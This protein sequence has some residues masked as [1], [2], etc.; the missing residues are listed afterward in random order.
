VK[1]GGLGPVEGFNRPNLEAK[2]SGAPRASDSLLSLGTPAKSQP[3]ESSSTK[4]E[5]DFSSILNEKSSKAKPSPKLND[6]NEQAEAMAG[7]SMTAQPAPIASDKNK[8]V[9]PGS[10]STIEPT[11]SGAH[12]NRSK[13]PAAPALKS[14]ETGSE[15]AAVESGEIS[16]KVID[17]VLGEL[18]AD[19]SMTSQSEE[20][21]RSSSMQDFLSQMKA[22]FGIQPEAVIK[23]FANLSP[24]ALAASPEESAQELL[25]GLGLKPDQMPKAERMYRDM[26]NVTGESALNETMAGVGAGVTMKVLSEQEV[27]LEKLQKSITSLNDSFAIRPPATDPTVIPLDN[28]MADAGAAVVETTVPSQAKRDIGASLKEALETSDPSSP[29]GQMNS[30]L[31]IASVLAASSA[32]ASMM[33]GKDSSGGQASQ[34][35]GKDSS[36]PTSDNKLES[37]ESA[38]RDAGFAIPSSAEKPAT[39]LAAGTSTALATA[40]MSQSDD[41]SMKANAQDVVRNAQLLLRN[42]GGEMKM[43]LKPEGVGEIHLKVAVKDGQVAVQMLT[44]SDSAKK[45]LE[46]GIEDLKTSLAQNKLHVDAL[47]I[48]V[49]TEMA[50]QRFEQSQQESGREQARQLAQ[51]FLGSFRQ[52]REAFRHGFADQSGFRSYG[53]PRRPTPPEMEQVA[54]TSNSNKEKNSRRLDLV[55]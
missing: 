18:V 5:K 54:S 16:Q 8:S 33:S 47:K 9:E 46:N 48:E 26:L 50:K 20:F 42:G 51:D 45:L 12:A 14:P 38:L 36:R 24:D 53:Q 23:A 37:I 21:V 44:E 22:E 27:A 55:A 31:G 19:L 17:Q 2:K 3:S 52:D 1:I 4:S 7:A 43:Q 39:P 10:D 13:Q 11:S 28:A 49:G 32:G 29:Q 6:R 25:A 35:A 41:A 40:M 34:D 30:D 15:V